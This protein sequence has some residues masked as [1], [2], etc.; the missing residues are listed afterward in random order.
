MHELYMIQCIRISTFEFSSSVIGNN[1]MVK[2]R[3][4]FLP[5]LL[6]WG[7]MMLTYTYSST[8]TMLLTS[9][10]D[11]C[12]W[13]SWYISTWHELFGIWR[14]NPQLK[15][16]CFVLSLL[17]WSKAWRCCKAYNTNYEWWEFN[18]MGHPLFMVIICLWYITP[19]DL[20][21]HWRRSLTQCATMWYG[22][23]LLWV[24]P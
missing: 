4:Q 13:D 7:E 12:L 11:N 1:S 21:W 10:H 15:L 23:Q 16:A 5:M 24:N 18:S 17:L 20:N 2:W 6:H 8:L 14:S 19:N 22:S 3:K 9:W